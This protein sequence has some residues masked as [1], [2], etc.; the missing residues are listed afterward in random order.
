MTVKSS[1]SRQNM[2]NTRKALRKL[3]SALSKQYGTGAP[4]ILVYGS[5]ARRE[6]NLDSD[7]DILL[8]YPNDIRSGREIYSLS[9]TLS[10]LNLRYQ[11][12]I[13]LLPIYEAEFERSTDPFWSKIRQEGIPFETV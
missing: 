6:A 9:S 4:K 10:E 11:V 7:I 12:L 8:I 5:Y 13:S 3:Q 2:Q 1:L